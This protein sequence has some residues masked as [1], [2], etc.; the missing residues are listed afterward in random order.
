MYGVRKY[1]S[2]FITVM[3]KLSNQIVDS[4]V[5]FLYKVNFNDTIKYGVDCVLNDIVFPLI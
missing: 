3:I 2:G 1:M 5:L 4:I